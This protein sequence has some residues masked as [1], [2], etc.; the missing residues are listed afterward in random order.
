[1]DHPR[2]VRWTLAAPSLAAMVSLVVLF[3]CQDS[4]TEPEFARVNNRYQLTITGTGS[5]AGGVVT[6]DRGGISCTVA[7]GGSVS[8][9]CSQGYKSGAV[10]TLTMTPSAGAKFES[11]SSN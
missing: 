9:K 3:A 10:V 2:S 8:G 6:S 1:M 5:T 11:A 7:S 4:L